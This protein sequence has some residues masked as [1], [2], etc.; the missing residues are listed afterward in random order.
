MVSLDDGADDVGGKQL[1]LETGEHAL[2]ETLRRDTAGVAAGARLAMAGAAPAI[3]G[4]D[5]VA[6]AAAAAHQAGEDMPFLPMMADRA[7]GRLLLARLGGS[8]S[9]VVD[10]AELGR[11]PFDQIGASVDAGEALA[12]LGIAHH[13]DAAVADDAGV[14]GV[15]EDAIVT[16]GRAV[17]GARPPFAAAR[18]GD[19]LG[20]QGMGDRLGRFPRDI[21]G[22]DP[23]DDRRL[24]LVDATVAVLDRAVG[25]HDGGDI[26]AVAA[27]AGDAAA[28][29]AP[30]RS[31]PDLG[32]HVLQL[33]R[34]HG[35]DEADVQFGHAVVGAGEERDAIE[36]QALE[37]MGDVAQVAGDAVERFR[38]D[39]VEL[40]PIGGG[41]HGVQI[42]AVIVLAGDGG[43]GIRG[44][45]VPAL[46]LSIAFAEPDLILGREGVLH[47]GAE[48]GVNG[49]A[50][51]FR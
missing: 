50:A 19:A 40:A 4:D 48:A 6:A 36:F 8:P 5:G 29:N 7:Q 15:A 51:P 10:D 26:V 41:E 25:M 24:G 45:D 46:A 27:S 21:G 23:A 47:V 18:A 11:L 16:L 33:E 13:A 14:D 37:D 20:I 12:A 22:E 42:G 39:D 2:L 49:D 17:D 32:A 31:A 30:L 38:E 43:V 35:A 44:D 9:R 3:T 34:A 1:V 28:R